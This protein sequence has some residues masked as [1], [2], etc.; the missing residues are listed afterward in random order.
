MLDAEGA[1]FHVEIH[2]ALSAFLADRL[3]LDTADLTPSQ[4][5]QLLQ[6]RSVPDA[7][8]DEMVAILEVCDLARFAPGAAGSSG[9]ADLLARAEDLIG[10]LETST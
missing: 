1:A 10:K 7:V 9:R 8:I 3:N 4:A 6:G 2:R 5:R